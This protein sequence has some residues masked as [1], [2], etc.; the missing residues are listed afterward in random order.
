MI[1]LLASVLVHVICCWIKN[2]MFVLGMNIWLDN[3][4]LVRWIIL[5]TR[6]LDFSF[7]SSRVKEKKRKEDRPF[8]D[9][10]ILRQKTMPFKCLNL[11]KLQGVVIHEHGVSW[12]KK[13]TCLWGVKGFDFSVKHMLRRIFFLP[14]IITHGIYLR[15]KKKKKTKARKK[16]MSLG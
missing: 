11:M 4:I 15:L 7:V 5:R 13:G 14:L 2:L 16:M 3:I 6:S 12:K 9:S 8:V 1:R 10:W